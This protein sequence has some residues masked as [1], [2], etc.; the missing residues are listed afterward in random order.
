LSNTNNDQI[1]RRIVHGKFKTS[2]LFDGQMV[3]VIFTDPSGDLLLEFD[4]F[5][6]PKV[7]EDILSL[8][9]SVF[10]LKTKGLW[11]KEQDEQIQSIERNIKSEQIK[12]HHNLKSHAICQTSRAK[13]CQLKQELASLQE[14]KYSMYHT[15]IEY[16]RESWRRMLMLP[17][18]V[19]VSDPLLMSNYQF[20]KRL[21]VLYY[22]DCVIADSKIR[23]LSRS[24]PWRVYWTASKDTGTPIFNGS[25]SNLTDNQLRLVHW[26]R[27]YDMAYQSM[28]R[29][30]EWVI[31][32][33]EYFDAWMVGEDNKTNNDTHKPKAEKKGS[34]NTSSEL[35]VMCKN[36]NEAQ[37]VYN[38][39]DPMAAGFVREVVQG[40]RKFGSIKEYNL[41]SV[42]KEVA[43][44]L[45]RAMASK[46]RGE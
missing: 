3:G 35:F 27:M 45:N 43:M 37:E 26:S 17:K 38:R 10:I 6:M 8:E 14:L 40:V 19:S 44:A 24:Y 12:I 23:Q 4:D 34:V 22:E 28:E 7:E 13:V 33:D 21:L 16:S 32:D 36:K 1:L 42:K 31:E 30:P 5:Y 41:P 20:T 39:N 18:M 15:T 29:P 11:S 25:M 9:E 2:V 46:M